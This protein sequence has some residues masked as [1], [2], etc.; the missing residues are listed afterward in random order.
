MIGGE[1]KKKTV[2]RTNEITALC[3]FTLLQLLVLHWWTPQNWTAPLITCG[4]PGH[5]IMMQW[6]ALRSLL[7]QR[8]ATNTLVKPLVASS[9]VTWLTYAVVCNTLWA[10]WPGGLIVT[11]FPA[12]HLT[13]PR[14]RTSITHRQTETHTDAFTQKLTVVFNVHFAH[15]V[16]EQ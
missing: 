4:S 7:S 6:A 1:H 8:W 10:V 11:A 14:V 9:H 16:C 13:S 5:R 12:G 2:K 3:L 15:I